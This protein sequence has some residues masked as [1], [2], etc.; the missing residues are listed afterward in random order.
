MKYAFLSPNGVHEIRQDSLDTVPEG[1]TELTDEQYA[2]FQQ[3]NFQVPV[4]VNG[5]WVEAQDPA[6]ILS[7]KKAAA[8]AAIAADQAA[9]DK[10]AYDAAHPGVPYSI[11][12]RQ[13]NAQ[14]K[15]EGLVLTVKA[16]MGSLAIDNT[17]RM[18]YEDSSL[19]ERDNQDLI[20]MLTVLGKNSAQ[21]DEFFIAASKL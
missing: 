9:A 8:A 15:S 21:A 6:V 18:A 16:Y 20:G 5:V 17:T 7:Q 19:W 14:L 10:A 11:T 1:A 13:G 12:K 4:L 2:Q 3:F